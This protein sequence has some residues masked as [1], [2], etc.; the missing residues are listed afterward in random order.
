MGHKFAQLAFTESVREVQS[1]LGSRSGY[2]RMDEGEDYN[3]ALSD[4]EVAFIEARDSFYMASVGETGWPYVQH[5]GGPPGFVRVLDSKT[6]GFAD[7]RGNRQYVTVGNVRKD[8]RVSLIFMDYPNRRRLK[9]LGRVKLIGNEDA[10]LLARL[11]ADDYDAPVERGFLIHVV[12]FD[13][14]CPQHITPR[15]SESEVE[16][17]IA[18][19]LEETRELPRAVPTPAP[20]A[21]EVLGDGTLD[22]V[23]SG[24]RQLTP[25]VRAYELRDPDGAMLPEVAAGAHIQVPV[26]VGG[27][28]SSVRH[29]SI[30]SAPAR[31]DAYEIAVLREDEGTG[32][33]RAVHEQL[34]V[35]SRLRCQ[36]PE[37]WFPLHEDMR[38][39][40]LIAGGI[41]ITPLRAMAYALSARGSAFEL[42]Y[43]AR[44]Y[45]EMAFREE[46]T[47]A[48]PRQLTAY[49]S[50]DGRRIDIEGVLHAAPED[51][52]FYVCGPGRLIDAVVRSAARLGIESDRVRFE[53]FTA[54]VGDEARPIRLELRRSKKRLVVGATQ[55]ILDAVLEAGVDAPYSCRAGNCRT[56]A[57]EVLDGV[58]DHRDSALS[59]FDR[60]YGRLIC[61]CVSRA[62]TDLLAI[63]L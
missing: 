4:R 10:A 18:T 16:T 43:A 22:L 9:L 59:T 5:R 46:L 33:S 31:R 40:V 60:D 41:G 32:G 54:T 29:Y 57:V 28:A 36:P 56:C 14:N 15:Y 58:A 7:F 30:S 61:T 52:V 20:G 48:F 6:L 3:D 24:V 27:G 42:H 55:T 39:A 37:N 45:P 12:A 13:W 19:R 38:P 26:E 34:G 25:R 2:A 50:A 51:A 62:Q 53:R 17:L 47:A 23:V 35:G 63:D 44:S 1:A 11:E 21:V 49:S 8:D